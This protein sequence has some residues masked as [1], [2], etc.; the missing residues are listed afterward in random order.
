MQDLTTL[1][2]LE[3]FKRR[4]EKIEKSSAEKGNDGAQGPKGDKGAD[5][6]QGPKG[7]KGP[8]GPKGP[9]GP[10]GP[11]GSDGK[12]GADGEDGV[13]V[14][15]IYTAADGDLVFVLSDDSELSVQ[16]PLS[17]D[18]N[19]QTIV[20][21]QGGSS[22]DGGPMGP[23]TTSMVATEPDV[24]FRDAKGRFKS[25]AVPDLKNQLEVNR[26]LLSQ[27][28]LNTDS[29]DNINSVGYD[30]TVIKADLAKE[31]QD[32]IDGD[33]DLQDQIDKLPPPANTSNFVK[34]TGDT[35][36]G[37]LN[38][39]NDVKANHLKSTK[40]DSGANSNLSIQRN[41]DTKILI[42]SSEN[43]SYQPLRYNS[44][45]NLDND[46]HLITKGY[47]D[48][49][50]AN[51]SGNGN[52]VS[53]TGGDSMEGPLEVKGELQVTGSADFHKTR[54]HNVGEPLDIHD[55]VNREYVDGIFERVMKYQTN[56]SNMT[57]NRY[58]DNAIWDEDNNRILM[59]RNYFSRSNQTSHPHLIIA[60]YETGNVE[61]KEFTNPFNLN[62]REGLGPPIKVGDDL[63][64]FTTENP[65][66]HPFI[67][68]TPDGTFDGFGALKI[69]RSW[70][71]L[72]Y[73]VPLT[74]RFHLI[75]GNPVDRIDQN[76]NGS[77]QA[78][79]T[80]LLDTEDL[81][82][83][84]Q[85]ESYDQDG[86]TYGTLTKSISTSRGGTPAVI[87]TDGLP[88]V[89]LI[90]PGKNIHLIEIVDLESKNLKLTSAWDGGTLPFD[91]L[92][93]SNGQKVAEKGKINGLTVVHNRYIVWHALNVGIMSFDTVEQTLT[94]IKPTDNWVE[95]GCN[96][97]RSTPNVPEMDGELYFLPG[98]S[99]GADGVDVWPT[100]LVV[101]ED[102]LS[103]TEVP[104]PDENFASTN[105]Q[106][107]TAL[108]FISFDQTGKLTAY[109]VN[110]RAFE[111][112]ESQYPAQTGVGVGDKQY[113]VPWVD[114]AGSNPDS[115]KE[116]RLVELSESLDEEI[117]ADF[118]MLAN[119]II[120][121][122]DESIQELQ[123][124]NDKAVES[125][126]KVSLNEDSILSTR[127]GLADLIA[128]DVI[129]ATEDEGYL[130]DNL[131]EHA[132]QCWP[133]S[134]HP[135]YHLIPQDYILMT[136]MFEGAKKTEDDR[137]DVITDNKSLDSDNYGNDDLKNVMI[138]HIPTGKI[139]DISTLVS[140]NVYAVDTDGRHKDKYPALRGHTVI[141]RDNGDVDIYSWIHNPRRNIKSEPGAGQPLH[142][143]HIPANP[144]FSDPFAGVTT[145]HTSIYCDPALLTTPNENPYGNYEDTSLKYQYEI[146]QVAWNVV[147]SATGERHYF[148]MSYNKGSKDYVT[149][150]VF[151]INF[152]DSNPDWGT[153]TPVGAHPE[154]THGEYASGWHVIKKDVNLQNRCFMYGSPCGLTELYF[155][156]DYHSRKPEI[157]NYGDY[158]PHGDRIIDPE[159]EI[160]GIG[161]PLIVGKGIIDNWYK[162]TT[163]APQF[164]N[165]SPIDNDDY[166]SNVIVWYQSAY[167]VCTLNIQDLGE[168]DRSD[169]VRLLNNY[170][171]SEIEL[172]SMHIET[173][174]F[175]NSYLQDFSSRNLMR[176]NVQQP[177]T[178]SHGCLY[179]FDYK[180][181]FPF[182][183]TDDGGIKNYNEE[184]TLYNS[185][186]M[187][188]MGNDGKDQDQ[189]IFKRP[190]LEVKPNYKTGKVEVHAI[191]V[192]SKHHPSNKELGF[193]ETM[194]GE[195]VV[196][197]GDV[198]VL[199]GA[200]KSH[201]SVTEPRIYIFDP[202][203]RQ[204][205][206]VSNTEV[207][208]TSLIAC[209]DH[210]IVIGASYGPDSKDNFTS[211]YMTSMLN[212][213]KVVSERNNARVLRKLCEVTGEDPA[214]VKGT[215][216]LDKEHR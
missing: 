177:D 37:V 75:V 46:R 92:V 17:T 133:T 190:I 105:S 208:T 215:W 150:R 199:S 179:F 21:S 72:N 148:M 132:V 23:V 48:E 114:G 82:N 102:V 131:M 162:S 212:S 98:S 137:G 187:G 122:H 109:N 119:P 12:E 40:I 30:D 56:P 2:L 13:G 50:V 216:A 8:E 31:T 106:R 138:L 41:N 147:D 3:K 120:K 110:D 195:S 183:I 53:K 176:F 108:E 189:V 7:P 62:R 73:T 14:V 103:V 85:V 95:Y 22:G 66:D 42:A 184:K 11:K 124:T 9:K 67:R 89:Y 36:S 142:R 77:R 128:A 91:H 4:I 154:S 207:N 49:A 144:D 214:K 54:I 1:M 96:R 166:F 33:A 126:A 161:V 100:M 209:P 163:L 90:Q 169:E 5:G 113:I 127:D 32:R 129:I 185:T 26:W 167:G 19:G 101:D 136:R 64:F 44:D 83:Q 151:K 28:E 191:V 55:A 165:Q 155:T 205:Q 47:V 141:P 24:L 125:I 99:K 180:A 206:R 196:K 79:A 135:L 39:N 174:D 15:D 51:S 107:T 182:D 143:I 203:T 27:I 71:V 130:V 35:M 87:E 65:K 29:I 194:S 198:F 34:K 60:D 112:L 111:R 213:D 134:D 156:G 118:N 10:E 200:F 168:T 45:Y 145:Q 158:T 197:F 116:C 153:I 68:L 170:Q 6:K 80:L 70:A 152:N 178:H 188:H 159:G 201:S 193:H 52:Y 211:V 58:V 76:G 94:N 186:R 149:Q 57:I 81:L 173:K 74:D 171:G 139:K 115:Y 172:S 18:E 78:Q 146:S 38:V 93:D 210:G 43:V 84:R 69:C 123:K 121:E 104:V 25:I 164:L 59:F 117:I 157:R 88:D 160:N 16:M 86:V 20:Y 192:G 204:I 97:H 202:Q 63:F 181:D 140:H 61:Y 175:Y